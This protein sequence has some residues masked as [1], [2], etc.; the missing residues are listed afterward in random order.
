[1]VFSVAALGADLVA[2]ANGESWLAGRVCYRGPAGFDHRRPG[3]RIY[4]R[5]A[6][7]GY[8]GLGGWQ[9]LFMIEG[10]PSVLVGLWAS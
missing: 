8:M 9:W 1:M 2:G 3:L 5:Y 10:V 6:V 4:S 7:D